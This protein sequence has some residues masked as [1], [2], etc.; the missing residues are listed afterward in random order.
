MRQKI[1]ELTISKGEK[2]GFNLRK[3]GGLGI[4]QRGISYS[5]IKRVKIVHF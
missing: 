4:F 3:G 5:K 2:C 1:N